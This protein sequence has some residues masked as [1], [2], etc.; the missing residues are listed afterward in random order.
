M[1]KTYN[2]IDELFKDKFRD[3]EVDPPEMVWENIKQNISDSNS[4]SMNLGGNRIIS[5]IIAIVSVALI[6]SYFIFDGENNES[7][8]SDPVSIIAENTIQHKENIE[9]V[10]IKNIENTET[11]ELSEENL[12]VEIE[13]ESNL[14]AAIIPEEKITEIEV[15]EVLNNEAISEIENSIQKTE[16]KKEEKLAEKPIDKEVKPVISNSGEIQFVSSDK[17]DIIYS[18]ET[19][20][21]DSFTTAIVS[22]EVISIEED[23]PQNINNK[24][25]NNKEKNNPENSGLEG[26]NTD[27][28]RQDIIEENMI[29]KHRIKPQISLGAYF[30]PEMIFYPSDADNKK[31]YTVGLGLNFDYNGFVIESG[32]GLSFS[33][34]NGNYRIDYEE[35]LGSY[36]DLLSITFDTTGPTVTPI[37][38]TTT[39]DVYDSLNKISISQ[40]KNSYTYLQIPL[41]FGFVKN[42]RRISY[43]LKG[44]PIMS[45]M[46]NKNIPDVVLPEDKIKV[47]K[48]DKDI[49]TRINTNWQFAIN[50]G[51]TYKLS[52]HLNIS[53]EPTFRYYLKSV[54]NNDNNIITTKHPY[55]L[56]IRTGLIY[57]F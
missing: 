18:D 5:I 24:L 38:H 7:I 8:A 14:E 15:E 23:L 28:Q 32:L 39:V 26:E 29:I 45:F 53:I 33:E 57:K 17:N 27:V 51:F 4:T 36:E 42:N 11:E 35:Y 48:I 12:E 55:S 21:S 16:P 2:N 47:I 52:N 6:T 30:T 46:I 31:A 25:D 34:D 37:F 10:S 22:Q 50:V 41:F 13:V 9:P 40:T 3:F 54:Y 19:V 20:S 43:S 49:P 1:K 56:G 44:G